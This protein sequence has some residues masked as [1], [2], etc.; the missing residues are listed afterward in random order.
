MDM[1]DEVAS[2][3]AL[4]EEAA[5][6]GRPE[7]RQMLRYVAALHARSIRPAKPPLPHDWEEI[8]PGYCFG[9]AFG[10]WDIV[11]Q[12]L[13]V[14]PSESGHA[15]RQIRNDL[16][17]QQPDGFLPGSIWMRDEAMPWNAN[18]A[19][20]PSWNPTTGH[21]PVWPE[22]VEEAFA[23]TQD[24]ALLAQ[25]HQ[26]LTRQ[27]VWFERNRRAKPDGFF[28]T[29][30]IDRRWESGVDQ[31]PRFQDAGAPD[32]AFVDATAH[33]Y[34]CYTLAA[35]WAD[36]LDLPGAE[37]R[38]RASQVQTFIQDHLFCAETGLFMDLWNVGRRNAPRTFDGMW[39]VVTG[40][41]RPDQADRV[42]RENLMNPRR[43]LTPH[44]L[45]TVAVD[46]PCFELRMWRGP[47]W[48]SMTFWAARGC[49]RYGHTDA[50]VRLL[51]AALDAS[52]LQFA[53]TGT[54]WEFYHPFAGSP[55]DVKRKGGATDHPCRDYLGHNPLL[56]M[57]RLHRQAL[58]R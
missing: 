24:W 15:I 17:N 7:W 31:G 51:R 40:A 44:P 38:D 10:H 28:Y 2:L 18:G 29:D 47:A 37:L 39:P 20:G 27:L 32:A 16:A 34:G 12:I 22:A 25:A 11:H 14:L 1:R 57:A 13:D 56:A 55:L 9:P 5:T 8:G 54:I 4:Q 43:F 41:A 58:E 50:A 6:L 36:R 3:P 48:N 49:L 26:A 19:R 52:A 33:V 42:I 46:S 30:L 35:R 21:P 45:A 53:Q 23:L